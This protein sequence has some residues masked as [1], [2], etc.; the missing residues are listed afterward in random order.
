M[1]TVKQDDLRVAFATLLIW[2]CNGFDMGTKVLNS[3]GG[4]PTLVEEP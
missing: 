2:A 1:F 4:Q 3:L